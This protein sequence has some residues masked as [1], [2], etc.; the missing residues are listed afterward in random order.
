MGRSFSLS[1]SRLNI[2]P[3]T[4]FNII[5]KQTYRM[6]TNLSIH[7]K[8]R[9]F[10]FLYWSAIANPFHF[11]C[12]AYSSQSQFDILKKFHRTLMK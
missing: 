7:L 3:K 9:I 6:P 11:L 4:P 5:F 12:G 1:V 10:L 2:I 8:R